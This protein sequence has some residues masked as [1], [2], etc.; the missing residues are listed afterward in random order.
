MSVVPDEEIGG[1]DGTER[2]AG[3]EEFKQL[4][5]G[6]VL[7]E[8]QAS[9]TE[10]FRVFYADRT[11]WR[12]I[13]KARGRNGHFAIDNL[14]DT[15]EIVARFRESNFDRVKA[16]EKAASEVVSINPAYFKAGISSPMVR[17][18]GF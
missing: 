18:M 14:M 5:V 1:K 4:Q 3:S 7:T 12:L 10:E 8:G 2:F 17:K 16:G 6:F 13:V 9:P 15:M 11:P